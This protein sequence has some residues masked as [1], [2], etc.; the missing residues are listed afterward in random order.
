MRVFYPDGANNTVIVQFE[1]GESEEFAIEEFV[2]CYGEDALPELKENLEFE[3]DTE[4]YWKAAIF[5][6]NAWSSYQEKKKLYI[7]ATHPETFDSVRDA[8]YGKKEK[9]YYGGNTNKIKR[10]RDN[11]SKEVDEQIEHFENVCSG[12]DVE[13]V[14]RRWLYH[15]LRSSADYASFRGKCRRRLS[16]HKPAESLKKL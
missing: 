8:V 3:L 6:I 12:F 16:K 9:R 2:E 4:I 15:H 5:L 14:S 10:R 13:P 1:D 7:N 11:L